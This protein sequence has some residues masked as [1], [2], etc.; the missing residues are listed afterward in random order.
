MPLRS[1]ASPCLQ[2][3]R[4]PLAK[5]IV[6]SSLWQHA[7]LIAQ[8]LLEHSVRFAEFRSNMTPAEKAD[9]LRLFKAC[10][11]NDTLPSPIGMPTR[12]SRFM[13]AESARPAGIKAGADHLQKIPGFAGTLA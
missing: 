13:H 2:N 6:F 4:P 1:R 10:L 7:R 8:Q 5:A 12:A 11:C 3:A 9:S